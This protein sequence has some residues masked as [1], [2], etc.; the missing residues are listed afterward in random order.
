MESSIYLK[1]RHRIQVHPDSSISLGRIAQ[2]IAPDAYAE[3]VKSLQIYQVSECDQNIIIID[4]MQVIGLIQD[5]FQGMDVQTIGPAQTIVE[6]VFKRKR[7]S[8][9]LFI[10]VW[11]L[12]FI[13][14]GLAIMNFHEDVSMRSVHQHLYEIITGEA[15][16]KPLIFQVPY[17]I[18]LGLGMILFFNH[19]F[20]KRINEE[21]SPLEVE[22][23]NYQLDLDQYVIMNENKE[24]MKHIDDD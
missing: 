7:M 9:P 19:V 23:F 10:L 12:L 15:N 2:I 22:M 17:S 21:P 18:G 13:G 16:S 6:V 3:R 11:L 1:L 5:H 4:V 24:S 20:R 8:V 14:A